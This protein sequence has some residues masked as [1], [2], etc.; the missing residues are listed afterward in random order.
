[1]DPWEFA[2]GPG[3]NVVVFDG[4][5]G[6]CTRFAHWLRKS[7]AGRL[8]SVPSQFPGVRETFALSREEANRSV[9]A[10]RSDGSRLSGAAAINS[11]FLGMRLPWSLLASVYSLPLAAA[12]E[13]QC[14]AWF[15]GHR[16]WFGWFAAV[17][18]CEQPDVKCR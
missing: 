6:V 3:A 11:V 4:A 17:P 15:A 14:Y 18:E 13:E 10:F 2:S 8:V 16:Q 1:M 12:I 5:C 7:G 9:W